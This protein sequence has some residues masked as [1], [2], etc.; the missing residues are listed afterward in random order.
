MLDPKL[1]GFFRN[2]FV[3]TFAEFALPWRTVEAGQIAAEFHAVHH[4]GAGLD[5][6]AGGWSGVAGIVAEF[7]PSWGEGQGGQNG[8]E[9][10]GGPHAGAGAERLAGGRSG[11]RRNVGQGY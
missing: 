4:A 3:D 9:F 8:A 7:A 10:P 11:G 6:L 2:A 5:R 1:P